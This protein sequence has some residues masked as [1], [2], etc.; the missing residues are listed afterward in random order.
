MAQFGVFRVSSIIV[1]FLRFPP[2]MNLVAR[3]LLAGHQSVQLLLAAH[4]KHHA[5][6]VT[7]IVLMA[8]DTVGAA[9]LRGHVFDL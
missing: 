5:S 3:G 2:S 6:G 8:S 9:E 4:F 1:G 7:H